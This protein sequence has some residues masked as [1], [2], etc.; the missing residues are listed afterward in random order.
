M[1][2]FSGEEELKTVVSYRHGR[3]IKQ[4]PTHFIATK[5]GMWLEVAH[6]NNVSN[7]FRINIKALYIPIMKGRNFS[8]FGIKLKIVGWKQWLKNL[9]VLPVGFLY[10]A[11]VRLITKPLRK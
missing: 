1:E 6:K 9:T 3:A 5:M 10:T 11:I 2:P 4:F 8:D 7:D